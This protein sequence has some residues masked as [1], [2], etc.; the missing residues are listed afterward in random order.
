MLAR[1]HADPP[2]A[3]ASGRSPPPTATQ[4]AP[5]RD[6]VRA[7]RACGCS[8]VAHRRAAR[9]A[10][11]V[12]AEREDAERD[13]CLIGLVAMLDPPRPEV[14]AAIERVHRAGIRVHV[15]TGDNGLTAAAIA[16][17]VGIGRGGLTV[18]TGAELDAMTETRARRPARRRPGDRLRAQLAR[19]QAAHRRRAARAGP[20]RRDD[21]RRGQRRPRAAPRRHRRR[22]GP[23]RHRRRPRGGHDGAHRRQLRHHRRP[24]S[25]PGGGST[26]TSASSSSTSSPTPSPR[27]CPFLVFALS[28]GAVPLPLTVMQ[29]LAIDL[30]TDTLP[31]LAL[32]REPAEPGLM[33][34]PPRPR[35]AGRDQRRDARPR[36]GLPR[37]DLGR[38]GHG[39]VLLHPAAR[40]LASRRPHRA[41]QPAAPRL[42]AGHHRGLARHRRLPDRHRVRRPH[43]PRLAALGRGVQQP[44]ACSAASPS[45]W[46]SP[47]CSS[48]CRCCT[49]SSAPPPS[50]RPAARPCAPFPF[51]VW[52]ADELRRL[53]LRRYHQARPEARS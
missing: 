19:G 14:P 51:I 33:D 38:A 47:R 5:R 36:L 42:P 18:V 6:R 3:S 25:R 46:P 49:A 26:T 1:C 41:G 30:G 22:D 4:V 24:P 40:R 17:R 10:P 29:I 43:R 23:L 12:P 27:S 2:T 21:R 34:R 28:G 8:R 50:P 16:R 37:P 13:L 11:P 7:R 15:V 20:G 44:P 32:G 9:P 53:I 35:S 48:T 52:G 31:A 45:P 39:R